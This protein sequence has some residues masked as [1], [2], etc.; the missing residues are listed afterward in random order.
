[1]AARTDRQE[2]ADHM[3]AMRYS[4]VYVRD[5]QTATLL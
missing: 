3:D 1:M 2:I 5:I 4:P